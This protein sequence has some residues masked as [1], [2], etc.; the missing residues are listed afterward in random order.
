MT[1]KLY[2]IYLHRPAQTRE[3]VRR[4]TKHHTTNERAEQVSDQLAFLPERHLRLEGS[5][6]RCSDSTYRMTHPGLW[7]YCSHI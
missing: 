1:T 4:L 5:Q 7:R 6:A 2:S 3:R